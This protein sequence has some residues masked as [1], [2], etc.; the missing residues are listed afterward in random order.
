MFGFN[1]EPGLVYYTIHYILAALFIVL[2]SLIYFRE[3]KAKAG[4]IQGLLLGIILVIT[5]TVLD[6]I[7]TVPLFT[8]TYDF[9]F[10]IYLLI[11][12]LETVVI[13]TVVGILR[14]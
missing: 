5:G 8:K 1:L 12:L 7:I 10:N 4:L 11:G 9:F 14:E 6:A 3:R 13:S 2:A